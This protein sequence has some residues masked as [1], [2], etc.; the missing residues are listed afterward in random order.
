M[1]Q[2]AISPVL[3]LEQLDGPISGA[4]VGFKPAPIVSPDLD[5]RALHWMPV[6][7]VRLHNSDLLALYSPEV[8]WAAFELWMRAWASGASRLAT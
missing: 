8:R 5:L 1:L 2:N 7:I 4:T 6:D 3:R